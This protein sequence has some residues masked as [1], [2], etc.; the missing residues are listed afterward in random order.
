MVLHW[1]KSYPT[2]DAGAA[3]HEL[4][5]DTYQ[6]QVLRG[7]NT[8]NSAFNDYKPFS[9]TFI[10][11]PNLKG[12]FERELT[13]YDNKKQCMK[14]N[15]KRYEERLQ[16]LLEEKESAVLW[17]MVTTLEP[18]SSMSLCTSRMYKQDNVLSLELQLEEM[19]KT[20]DQRDKFITKQMM[21]VHK[22]CSEQT[23]ME[24][25]GTSPTHKPSLASASMRHRL[26][27]FTYKCFSENLQTDHR[28]QAF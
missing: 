13:T 2:W 16:E 17:C 22:A 1:L 26:L 7:L 25:Q 24:T 23:Q 14:M 28:K 21:D 5:T 9:N 27:S 20:L 12:L 10:N 4:L 6:S 8:I 18:N 11:N 15:N 3:D 19:H